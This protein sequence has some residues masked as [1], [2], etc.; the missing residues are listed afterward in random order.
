MGKADS[1]PLVRG[2]KRKEGKKWDGKRDL[3]LS[4]L[5]KLG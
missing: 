2:T 5:E 4:L 1:A 3:P